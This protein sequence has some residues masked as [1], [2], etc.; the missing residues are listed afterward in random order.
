MDISHQ[1]EDT[2]ILEGLQFRAQ[3]LRASLAI[4]VRFAEHVGDDDVVSGTGHGM[5]LQEV[6][7]DDIDNDLH[8]PVGQ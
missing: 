2:R 6:Q 3:G 5:I 8:R 1:G 4:P 7:R